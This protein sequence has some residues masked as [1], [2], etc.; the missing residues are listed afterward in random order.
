[1]SAAMALTG[2]RPRLGQMSRSRPSRPALAALVFTGAVAWCCSSAR[3]AGFVLGSNSQV[4]SRRSPAVARE[5]YAWAVER[6]DDNRGVLL[7]EKEAN[8]QRVS[9]DGD[10][11]TGHYNTVLGNT[12]LP[13][14]G[15]H[16][17]EVKFLKK[18]TDAWEYIGLAEPTV[19]LSIPL[20]NNKG[21]AK[22]FSYAATWDEFPLVYTY[23]EMKPGM[24]D[25]TMANRKAWIEDIATDGLFK[26]EELEKQVY[27]FEKNMW[28]TDPKFGGPGAMVG[29]EMFSWPHFKTGTVIGVDVD[30]DVGTLAFWADG[31]YL[32]TVND[33]ASG[34]PVNIKG[35]KLV[36]A[37]TIYGRRTNDESNQNTVLEVRTDMTPP[38]KP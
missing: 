15:R 4:L 23:M 24:N 37:M 12:E 38:A 31:K 5:G 3:R 20:K 10:F 28:S 13:Q 1:V 33:H 7:A 36:P 8:V 21:G 16:Y 2:T 22:S 29:Q 32:G 17:W 35:M 30:M 11:N 9:L 26:K 25:R 34:K 18:P 27:E 19:N 14:S 6:K